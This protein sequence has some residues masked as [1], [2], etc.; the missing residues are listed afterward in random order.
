MREATTSYLADAPVGELVTTASR[1]PLLDEE[2][3]LALVRRVRDGDMEA[4]ERLVMSNLRVAVDEA[5][6]NRGLGQSQRSLVRH[7]ITVLL[8]SARTYDP[9]AHG[10]FSRYVTDRVRNALSEDV[11]HT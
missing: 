1:E 2:R 3:E 9:D 6:R 4:L 8:E 10:T 11:S 5:I 7:G